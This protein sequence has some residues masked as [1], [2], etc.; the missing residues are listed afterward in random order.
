MKITRNSKYEHD[1]MYLKLR[2]IATED[3]ENDTNY[4]DDI[5][6]AN[7]PRTKLFFVETSQRDHLR[8]L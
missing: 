1:V 2:P 7:D 3:E 6:I 5:N 4:Y 8:K